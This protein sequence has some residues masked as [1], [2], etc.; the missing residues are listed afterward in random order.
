MRARIKRRERVRRITII[1][2]A[3]VIVVSLV[4]GFYF[5]LNTTSPYSSFVGKPVS[6]SIMADMTGVSDATLST[7]GAPSGVTPPASISGSTLTLNGKPEVLYV[8]GDYCPYCAVERWSL[9]IALSRFGTFSNLTYMLSSASDVNP[10][11]PTFTFAGSSYTSGYVAFV[12]VE[13]YGSDPN[14]VRQPLTSDQQSLV[15]QFDTCASTGQKSGIPFIDIANTYAVN[16][17]AQSTLDVSN[18]NWTDI[19]PLLDTPSSNTARLIDGAAN[20]LITAICKVE[21][22][23]G[24]SPPVCSQSYANVTL[25]YLTPTASGPATFAMATPAPRAQGTRLF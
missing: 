15:S 19:A 22:S 13:E 2:V 24:K 18:K 17:G 16:C 21:T 5:A 1:V 12:G 23:L 25:S 3:A 10:S 4:V 6:G 7:I 14:T 8:G 11:T 9:I 20:T